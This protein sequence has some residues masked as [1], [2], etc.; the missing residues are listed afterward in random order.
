MCFFLRST[1]CTT[2]RR[3][4]TQTWWPHWRSRR[5]T[6]RMS[7]MRGLKLSSWSLRSRSVVIVL[8]RTSSLVLDSHIYCWVL[9]AVLSCSTFRDLTLPCSTRT[10]TLVR[11]CPWFPPRPTQVMGWGTS[12]ACWLSSLRPCWLADWLIVMNFEHRSWR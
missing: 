10:K 6:P 12:S 1:V 2:G 9:H 8:Y 3:V 11:L 4:Q 5:K 7:L